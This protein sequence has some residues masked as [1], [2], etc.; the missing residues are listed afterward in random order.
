MKSCTGCR[1]LVHARG[2]DV[3]SGDDVEPERR[4]DPFSGRIETWLTRRPT[5]RQMRAPGDKCGPDASLWAPN[6]WRR[7]CFLVVD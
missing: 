3:C 7:I 1:H 6:F 2:Y 4:V 5:L